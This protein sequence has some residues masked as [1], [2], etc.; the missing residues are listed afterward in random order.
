M[1]AV[2]MDVPQLLLP[3]LEF[4]HDISLSSKLVRATKGRL[5]VGVAIHKV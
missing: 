1:K 5:G 4:P 2:E 3:T